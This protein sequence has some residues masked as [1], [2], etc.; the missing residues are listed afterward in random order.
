[1]CFLKTEGFSLRFPGSPCGFFLLKSRQNRVKFST[2]YFINN[3]HGVFLIP[4]FIVG[5]MLTFFRN[6]SFRVGKWRRLV[7]VLLIENTKRKIYF[8]KHLQTF[9]KPSKSFVALSEFNEF[10]GPHI[11]RYLLNKSIKPS[12]IN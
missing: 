8:Y 6:T 12:L 5:K 4:A 3:S 9:W 10:L 1:M 7:S 11:S 2:I